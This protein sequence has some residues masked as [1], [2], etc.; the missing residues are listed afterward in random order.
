MQYTDGRSPGCEDDAVKLVFYVPDANAILKAVRDA[1]YV[2]HRE[3]TENP[4]M[5]GA[6]IGFARD[7]DGYL[8]ELIQKPAKP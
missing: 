4:S 7:P 2:V 6:I 8:I 3:A 1:N 5:G